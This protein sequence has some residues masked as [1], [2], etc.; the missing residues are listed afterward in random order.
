MVGQDGEPRLR[1]IFR[2]GGWAAVAA[3]ALVFANG[4]LLIFYPIPSTV[5]G[6][7][8]QIQGNELIGLVNLDLVML[9]SEILMVPV[10]VALYTALRRVN[11][12]AVTLATGI[13]LG[14]I[15]LYIAI[16]PTLS[17]LYLSDQYAVASSAAQR[18]S[19]LAAGEALWANYQGTAFAVSYL[20]A[21]AA[22]LVFASVMLRS[23]VF[24]RPTAWIGLVYG[25]LLLV[26][27]MPAFGTVGVA[28]SA[29]ALL[30]MV[31]FEALLAWRLLHLGGTGERSTAG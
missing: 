18:A 28:I 7:F 6:H 1:P 4:V 31:V 17:F 8:Q 10:Y 20:M 5:L 27:P 16:N 3:I 2:I 14:G 23:H 26:P 19:L 30:P 15:L 9:A 13:A 21:A 24:N 12:P 29:V 22:T 11:R 25:A